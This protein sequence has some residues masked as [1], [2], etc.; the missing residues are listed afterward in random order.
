MERTFTHSL[1][2]TGAK[3]IVSQAL[4][5]YRKDY[6]DNEPWF[7]W[8]EDDT[9]VFGFTVKKMFMTVKLNG[10]IRIKDKAVIIAFP[11]V[12]TIAKPFIPQAIKVIENE[13]RALEEEY[14][15]TLSIPPTA[16]KAKKTL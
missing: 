5:R 9:V 1:D 11:Q 15:S 13:I 7:K 4:A 6:P 12:P 8:I 2:I 16:P 3:F 14:T 10:I